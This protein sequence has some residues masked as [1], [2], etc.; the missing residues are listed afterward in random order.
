MIRLFVEFSWMD[1]LFVP[2]RRFSLD[3]VGKKL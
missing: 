2:V 3:F 1:N